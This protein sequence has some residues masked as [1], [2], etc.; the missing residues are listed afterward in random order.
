M[1][2][3][4]YFGTTT[5]SEEE[6]N[7]NLLDNLLDGRRRTQLPQSKLAQS[8]HL[9]MKMTTF[10][11]EDVDTSI[12][13]NYGGRLQLT[14]CAFV[15]NT[16][17][18]IIRSEEGIVAVVSTEFSGNN[19]QGNGSQIVLDSESALE[20]NDDN[21]LAATNGI[22]PTGTG[23]ANTNVTL[24]N[25]RSCD[26][27]IAGGVCSDLKTCLA[28]TSVGEQM[29]SCFSD[30]DDLVVAVRDRPSTKRDFII[31]PKSTLN[32]ASGPVVIDG[33]YITIQ[34]GTNWDKDCVISGGESHFKV[35]GPSKGIQLARLIMSGATESSI[36]ALGGKGA[37]LNL[38]DCEWVK[39]EGDSAI[40]IHNEQIM[41]LPS[42]GPFELI[43][44]IALSPTAA[45][46]VEV[47]DCIFASNEFSFGAIANI[48]G[49]L[50]VYRSRF[51]ENSALGGDI[52]VT[53]YGDTEVRESCF[54][55]ASSI[56]PGTIF[57][58]DGS[59]IQNK[60]NFGYQNTAGGYGDG[61]TCVDVFLEMKDMSCIV[62]GSMNCNGVCEQFT[63]AAC[64]LDT[65]DKIRVPYY[66]QGKES[67]NLIP[68]VVAVVVCAFIIFGFIGI[69]MRRQ[70]A[71][72]RQSEGDR[73]GRA[74]LC[75]WK[76]NGRNR[77]DSNDE[78]MENFDDDDNEPL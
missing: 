70:K 18:S 36:L 75:C 72:R 23:D 1:L 64:P 77:G 32:A 11:S 19:L 65:G 59:S 74:G 7:A 50:I 25:A 62:D 63:M 35:V 5:L 15:N 67:S 13:E 54:N 28:A 66:N 22:M 8:I 38:Q 57:V 29:E 48:G 31:C 2:L 6:Q 14:N 47:I 17:E 51:V 73:S 10:T 78:E 68:I 39:N 61:D 56:A 33:S 42:E 45:M 60:D 43:K 46:S 21:C 24:A 26:G 30:W 52:I 9:V 69:V 4:S 55:S 71:M 49:T 20:K 41:K 34:C 53:N 76:K 12:I 16:A 27:I 40:L 58:Q 37:T 3:S 44:E